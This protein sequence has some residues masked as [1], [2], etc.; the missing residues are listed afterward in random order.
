MTGSKMTGHSKHPSRAPCAL[1]AL[2]LL[3]LVG[4]P[5]H[6]RLERPYPA[7]SP[8]ALREALRA[9]QQ[10]LRALNGRVRATSWM[11]GERVRATVLVLA[12]RPGRLRLEAQVTL[13]GT[14]AVLATDGAR[15]AF[16]DT[17]KNELRRGPACPANVA[18]LIRIPLS[19]PDVAAILLGDAAVPDGSTADDRVTWDGDL[20]VDVL[21]VAG[22]GGGRLRFS[23]RRLDGQRIQIVGVTAVGA[24]GAPLWRV[25]F[26]DF[27]EV[28]SSTVDHAGALSLPGT[29]RFADGATSFDEGVEIDF[30]ERT[31][32][33]PAAPEAF[34]LATP[35]GVTAVEVGCP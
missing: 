17:R 10:D 24:G 34:V 4:C 21:D 6:V 14:V 8:A 5:R 30:K 32:N 16:L 7:P 11:G 29:I 9:R 28:P 20:G 25:A 22:P 12:E 31:V 15:F 33:D 1:V 23:V 2:A 35:P 19:P 13:Q 18:S 26:E 3:G 27:V